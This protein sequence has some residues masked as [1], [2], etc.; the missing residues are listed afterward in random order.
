MTGKSL[1]K[2]PPITPREA[3]PKSIRTYL[4]LIA[5]EATIESYKASRKAQSANHSPTV[6]L[7]R[8]RQE[9]LEQ[10]ESEI[11][12]GR[13]VLWEEVFGVSI[14]SN[15]SG[16]GDIA[17]VGG[18]VSHDW[19]DV[20]AEGSIFKKLLD[21]KSLNLTKVADSQLALAVT[22]SPTPITNAQLIR[23]A[24]LKL[25]GEL[26]SKNGSILSEFEYPLDPDGADGLLV[27][28]RT[29]PSLSQIF[30]QVFSLPQRPAPPRY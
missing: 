9:R 29:H 14:G 3:V 25:S 10:I 23:F 4:T 19:E 17:T 11:M 22:G 27:I 8:D 28:L 21:N 24:W 6:S 5:D 7:V 13:H 12:H 18:I 30:N 1:D 16:A 2:L 26:T 20:P 15:Y